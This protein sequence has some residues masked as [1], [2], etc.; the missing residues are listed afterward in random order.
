MHRRETRAVGVFGAALPLHGVTGRRS[1]AGRNG[2]NA[3]G[4]LG[5]P[6]TCGWGRVAAPYGWRLRGCGRRENVEH[7]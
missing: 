7:N 5:L 4:H 2:S 1:L 6:V 3:L